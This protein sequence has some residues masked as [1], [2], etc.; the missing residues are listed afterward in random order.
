ML[1]KIILGI[2]IFLIVMLGLT[3]G[4]AIFHYISSYLGFLFHDFIELMQE[5]QRSL[6]VHWS[7]ALISL[8]ITVPL[9]IWIS[10]I[11]K[12]EMSKPNSRR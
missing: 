12:D 6:T 4:E 9:V 3:F 5:V 7:K 1:Q 8:I 11:K 10:K 2:A